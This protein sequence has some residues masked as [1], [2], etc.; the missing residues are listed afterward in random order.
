[1]A[2]KP[3]K[4]IQKAVPES[5]KGVFKKKAEAAGKTT[6][7]FAAEHA[8]DKGTLGKEARL[9]QTLMRENPGKERRKRLYK[10]PTSQSKMKE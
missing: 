1:M 6:R 7:E 3:K 9:A 4:W 5:R 8:G 2:D 10:H